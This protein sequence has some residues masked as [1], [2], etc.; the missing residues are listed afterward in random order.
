M[1]GRWF[2]RLNQDKS[3]EKGTVQW[4]ISEATQF[5][6]RKEEKS[7]NR[8]RSRRSECA[9]RDLVGTWPAGGEKTSRRS[10]SRRRRAVTTRREECGGERREERNEI[11]RRRGRETVKLSREDQQ[12]Q[13]EN[14]RKT[15][16]QC[17][18]EEQGTMIERRVSVLRTNVGRI[19]DQTSSTAPTLRNHQ[20]VVN[21]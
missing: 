6:E 4:N 17:R 19:L 14:R 3:L 21:L 9:R 8:D 13:E 11:G 1:D 18:T 5:T 12:E 7:R 2:G 15:D 20:S 16:D 10:S